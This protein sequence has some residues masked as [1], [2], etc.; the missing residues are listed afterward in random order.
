ME[1]AETGLSRVRFRKGVKIDMS[2]ARIITAAFRETDGQPVVLQY[3]RMVEKLCDEMPVFIKEGELIVGDPNGGA[4]KVRWHPESNVDWVPESVTTGGFS[5][6]V[7]DEERK[8][9]VD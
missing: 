2:R 7:T 8:E 3:A 5:E 1:N 4:D 9:I 6:L